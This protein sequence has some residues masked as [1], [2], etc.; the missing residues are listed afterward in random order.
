MG[1]PLAGPTGAEI[2]MG[3]QALGL[4]VGGFVV[5]AIVLALVRR[6]VGGVF[7]FLPPVIAVGVILYVFVAPLPST[8]YPDAVSWL[9]P[10]VQQLRNAADAALLAIR[11]GAASA[12]R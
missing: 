7:N 8:A 10:L 12:T 2:T 4:I 1:H 6:V 9:Y 11:S 3:M 5:L